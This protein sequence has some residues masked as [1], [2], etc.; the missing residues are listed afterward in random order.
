MLALLTL[1]FRGPSELKFCGGEYSLCD[2]GSCALT[3]AA[4]GVC[5]AGQY[6]CPLSTTCLSSLEQYASH[7][8]GLTGTHLDWTLS[9]E[10]R[11]DEYAA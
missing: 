2:D 11:L 4:C 6:V 3:K 5:A 10:Q 7:C 1:A 9:E 8:P